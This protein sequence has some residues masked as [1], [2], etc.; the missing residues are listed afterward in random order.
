M[1]RR[2][3]SC[4]RSTI[5]SVSSSAR[6]SATPQ[7][8]A[9]GEPLL[10]PRIV[11][12][13]HQ[14]SR[15]WSRSPR[16]PPLTP[17]LHQ[18]AVDNPA[19]R[20][21]RHPQ[22][23]RRPRRSDARPRSRPSNRRPPAPLWGTTART[24][25]PFATPH[26]PR[27]AA[28]LPPAARRAVAR[29]TANAVLDHLRVLSPGLRRHHPRSPLRRRFTQIPGGTAG[30]ADRTTP[31]SYTLSCGS[32]TRSPHPRQHRV[33]STQRER[34]AHGSRS[35]SLPGSVTGPV[36]APGGGMHT[37]RAKRR[38][39]QLR[40]TVRTEMLLP[41]HGRGRGRHSTIVRTTF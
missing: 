33:T 25:R 14:R 34:A 11:Y 23:R 12:T 21:T 10:R 22:T 38:A 40:R 20:R 8:A 35:W 39:G 27:P 3:G 26:T 29:T 28:P 2:R 37:G 31:P 7:S 19:G 18:P 15:R 16:G 17:L 24:R 13:S 41:W 30:M 1:A 5:Y 4:A 6:T 9:A 32:Y 36:A